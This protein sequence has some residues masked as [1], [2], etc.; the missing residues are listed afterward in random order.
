ML[1]LLPVVAAVCFA[2]LA[3]A[4][5][6]SANAVVTSTNGTVRTLP[7]VAK[8]QPDGGMRFTVKAADAGGAKFVAIQ[9][10]CAT[11]LKGDDGYWISQRGLLGHFTRDVGRWQGFRNWLIFFF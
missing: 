7:L 6:F 4:G 1:S 2:C 8:A 3:Q 9:A 11:A 10:D 5:G